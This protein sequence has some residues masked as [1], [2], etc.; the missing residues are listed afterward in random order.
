MNRTAEDSERASSLPL[1]Q[2]TTREIAGHTCTIYA[3]ERPA[4]LLIQP[5][6]ANDLREMDQEVEAIA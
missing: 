6:D 2:K 3:Q 4:F 1:H 5:A